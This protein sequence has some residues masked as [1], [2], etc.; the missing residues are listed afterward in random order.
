MNSQRKIV[1]LTPVKNEA[2][3]LE[4]FLQVTSEFADLI[5]VA[6]Q[7][8]TDGS[9]EICRKFP[10][11]H[12]MKNPSKKYDESSRQKLLIDTAR[13]LV[14][15]ERILIALD[16]DEILAA[17]A[18]QDPEWQKIL[19]A[20]PGTVLFFEKPDLY[21]TTQNVIRYTKPWPLGYVDD[22]A[23]HVAKVVHS[24]RIPVP[25][26][27]PELHLKNIKFLHYGLTRLKAQQAKIRLYS[28]L[29]NIHQTSPFWR[30]RR[31]YSSHKTYTEAGALEKSPDEWFAAW[32]QKGIDMHAIP[33]EPFYWQDFEVLSH[34]TTYGERK[35]WCDDIWN[36]DWRKCRLE[37]MKQQVLQASNSPISSPPW[38]FTLLLKIMDRSISIIKKLRHG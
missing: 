22:N 36:F 35:F 8:S 28:V 16:A 37:A 23:E 18:L 11:V 38:L 13:R 34:F 33:D 19:T 17:N 9:Q 21:E 26:N 10:K 31:V 12:W 3:I 15:G 6:D 14:P 5:V 4:R 27:A 24:I 25:E 32:N 1:V 2:W 30:R 7:H 20:A 29:E